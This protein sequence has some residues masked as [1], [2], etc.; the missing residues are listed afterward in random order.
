MAKYMSRSE[1]SRAIFARRFGKKSVPSSQPKPK[2]EKKVAPE[3]PK[4]PPSKA[5]LKP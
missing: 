1:H 4:G 3:A 2:V 5:D